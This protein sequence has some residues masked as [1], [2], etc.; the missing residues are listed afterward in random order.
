MWEPYLV[1]GEGEAFPTRCVFF[2]VQL[3]ATT[4]IMSDLLKGG[5]ATVTGA[6]SGKVP[7]I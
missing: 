1:L 5:T 3:T 6:A 2:R 4:I 7:T